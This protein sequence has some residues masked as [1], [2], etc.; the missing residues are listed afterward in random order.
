MND[1]Q[2][3]ENA[4][5]LY[6]NFFFSIGADSPD[7]TALYIFMLTVENALSMDLWFFKRYISYNRSDESQHVD[8]ACKPVC[9]IRCQADG[10]D[11]LN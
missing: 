8:D 1:P 2:A 3:H 7:I 10:C 6:D 4:L 11:F 9:R 5:L